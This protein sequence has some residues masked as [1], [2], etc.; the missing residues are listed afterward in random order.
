MQDVTQVVDFCSYTAILVVMKILCAAGFTDVTYT[1]H[2]LRLEEI[3]HYGLDAIN[4][5]RLC[6]SL[7]LVFEDQFSSRLG[8]CLLQCD[9][10]VAKTTININIILNKD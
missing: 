7:R 3:M 1:F 8:E 9:A 6:Q 2:D 4:L 5:W 10:L